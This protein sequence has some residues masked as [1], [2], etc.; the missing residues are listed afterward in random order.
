MQATVTGTLAR[1]TRRRFAATGEDIDLTA[2][3]AGGL[4]E[5]ETSERRG[6]RRVERH[7]RFARQSRHVCAARSKRPRALEIARDRVDIGAT[8]CCRRRRPRRPREFPIDDGRITTR[9]RSPA[10]RLPRLARLAGTTLPFPSTLVVGGDWSLAATPRLSGTLNVRRE[11]G[12]WFATESTTLD[13]SDLALGITELELSARV[14]RRCAHGD[15]AL[16]FR[17]RGQRRRHGDARG[18][19]ACR[20]ASTPMRRS[21]R[22]SPPISR[23]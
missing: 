23:R 21:L 5:Y 17:A 2:A 7:A 22:T 16:S 11:S 20:D 10:F 19:A 9:D 14:G 8:A 13:P 15:G 6:R 3:F 12:D 1:S 18:R 4:A